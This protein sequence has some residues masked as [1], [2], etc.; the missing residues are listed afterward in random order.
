VDPGSVGAGI[1]VVRDLGGLVDAVLE[2]RAVE[3]VGQ[4]APA[5]RLHLQALQQLALHREAECVGRLIPLPL[6]PP[7]LRCFERGQQR[8]GDVGGTERTTHLHDVTR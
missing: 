4:R 3:P 7:S 1:E 6:P 5:D 2:L 8:S